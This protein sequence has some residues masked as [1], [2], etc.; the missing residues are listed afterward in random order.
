M[1]TLQV[2]TESELEHNES[3]WLKALQDQDDAAVSEILHDE[4]TSTSSR[5]SDVVDKREYL[6]SIPQLYIRECQLQDVPVHCIENVGIVKA[7]LICDST[8]GDREIYDDLFITD[9]WMK[10][11]N[12]WKVVTRH[13]SSVPD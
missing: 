1:A 13:A 7:R 11:G 9:V 4:F 2:K 5:S 6:A 8:A 12:A 10:S 3:L